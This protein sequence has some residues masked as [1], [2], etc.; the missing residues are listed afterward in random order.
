MMFFLALLPGM[1]AVTRLRQ[2]KRIGDGSSISLRCRPCESRDPYA[3][4]S[5]VEDGASARDNNNRRWLWVPAFAGTTRGE[6]MHDPLHLAPLAG[7][8]RRVAPGEGVDV[9]RFGSTGKKE[10]LTPT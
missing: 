1:F 10:P 6:W 3:E 9:P 8:G 4:D 7:R 5:Q 2:G